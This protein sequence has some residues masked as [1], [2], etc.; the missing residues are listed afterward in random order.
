MCAAGRE[1]E[2]DIFQPYPLQPDD[3]PPTAEQYRAHYDRQLQFYEKF[4]AQPILSG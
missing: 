4:L 2:V 1:K 3:V